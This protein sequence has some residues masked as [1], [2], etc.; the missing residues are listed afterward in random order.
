MDN[1]FWRNLWYGHHDGCGLGGL[2]LRFACCGR[3]GF[4]FVE[5]TSFHNVGRGVENAGIE[6]SDIKGLYRIVWQL[7]DCKS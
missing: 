5:K 2:G 1:T 4:G 6:E 7:E 3:R